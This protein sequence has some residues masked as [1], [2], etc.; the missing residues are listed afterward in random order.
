MLNRPS[1][2]P[3]NSTSNTHYSEY[4]K[5]LPGTFLHEILYGKRDTQSEQRKPF[6]V[7]N[8]KNYLENLEKNYKY[9]GVPFKKPNV[10]EIPPY[11]NN[12][13]P[14]EMHIEYLDTVTVKLNVLKSGKVR[15]KLSSQMMALNENYY[16]KGKPPPIKSVLSAL[17]N[18]GY[19]NESIDGINEKYKKRKKL[20]E[21]K[22]KKLESILDAPSLSRTTKKKSKKKEK[23]KEEEIEEHKD[24]EPSDDIPK[25]DEP[26]E[27]EGMDMEMDIDEDDEQNEEEY[28]S[29]GGED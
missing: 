15:V 9:Y 12:S 28:V 27:D 7:Q 22:W 19:S 17:K 13:K 3:K 5:L 1:P 8:H 11:E 14:V 16:S 10:E 21:I 20:I 26:E 25:S 18:I 6:Y 29:D 4:S 24:D 23:V 2:I